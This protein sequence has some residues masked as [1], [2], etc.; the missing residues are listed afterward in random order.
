[1]AGTGIKGW[2]GKKSC[3]LLGQNLKFDQKMEMILHPQQSSSR[4]KFHCKMEV[5]NFGL[6][7][8]DDMRRSLLRSIVISV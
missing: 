7:R 2:S 6:S 5:A 1:M 8:G 4:V 3:C